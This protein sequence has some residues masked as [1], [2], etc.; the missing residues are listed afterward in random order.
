MGVKCRT[1]PWGCC[2]GCECQWVNFRFNFS[3]FCINLCGGCPRINAGDVR[4]VRAAPPPVLRL[5]MPAASG[6]LHA[7]LAAGT[8]RGQRAQGHGWRQEGEVKFTVKLAVVVIKLPVHNAPASP[9]AGSVKMTFQ[10]CTGSSSGGSGAATPGCVFLRAQNEWICG[11]PAARGFRRSDAG[12]TGT[13]TMW[14][15]CWRALHMLAA[16]TGTPPP[17]SSESSGERPPPP[18]TR[19]PA[20]TSLARHAAQRA[21]LMAM[22][23]CTSA[24]LSWPYRYRH[25][26][27]HHG[28]DL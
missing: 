15:A 17:S 7:C 1:R 21:V 26:T 13:G 20:T 6:C 22:L 12:I 24:L 4:L 16:T 9:M 11:W 19:I 8:T 18:T 10:R 14:Q 3:I 2:V 5:A 25:N 28:S 27:R 23:F